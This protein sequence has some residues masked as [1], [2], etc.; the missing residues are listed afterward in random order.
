MRDALFTFYLTVTLHCRNCRTIHVNF[1]VVLVAI[2]LMHDSWTIIIM[3]KKEHGGPHDTRAVTELEERERGPKTEV[4][5]GEIQR[6]C[7]TEYSTHVLLI[8]QY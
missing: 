3:V 8:V 4:I 6:P 2:L 7:S 1:L 5:R